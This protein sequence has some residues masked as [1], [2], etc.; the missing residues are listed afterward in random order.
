MRRTFH[1]VRPAPPARQACTGNQQLQ[2][3]QQP[4]ART[5][6]NGSRCPRGAT[7]ICMACARRRAIQ[8]THLYR[9]A[10]QQSHGK[11]IGNQVAN[12]A[13][14]HTW[15][16]TAVRR[17]GVDELLH[18]EGQRLHS[19]ASKRVYTMRCGPKTPTAYD[20]S[21]FAHASCI[22]KRRLTSICSTYRDP[23]SIHSHAAQEI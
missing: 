21:P 9:S 14:S 16:Y 13:E 19:T 18:H 8:T 4:T 10:P 11:S 22:S 6:R 23:L 12:V 3:C 7:S 20:S 15:R 5:G 17:R 1:S 2:C